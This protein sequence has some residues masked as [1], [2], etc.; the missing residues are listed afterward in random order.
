MISNE[1]VENSTCSSTT[2]KVIGITGAIGVVA[3]IISWMSSGSEE[4]VQQE[5][6]MKAPIHLVYS[7]SDTY[8]SLCLATTFLIPNVIASNLYRH[9]IENR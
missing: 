6:M 5:K 4:K 2:T 9:Q 8:I 7:E 1:I 3:G